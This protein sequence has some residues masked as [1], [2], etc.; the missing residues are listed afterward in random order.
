MAQ[1]DEERVLGVG[2]ELFGNL[3]ERLGLLRE[4]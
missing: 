4:F 2:F 3:F 1:Y